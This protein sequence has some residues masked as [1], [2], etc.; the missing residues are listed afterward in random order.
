VGSFDEW[1]ARTTVLAGPLAKLL[2]SLPGEAKQALRARANEATEPYETST[3]LEFPGV[4][5][6]AAARRP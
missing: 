4:T 2:H 3:G 6:L 5:L 1:W